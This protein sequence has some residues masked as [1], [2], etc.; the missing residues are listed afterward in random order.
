MDVDRDHI[1]HLVNGRLREGNPR[2]STRRADVERMVGAALAK[3][4]QPHLVV[5]FH[6]GLVNEK[7]GRG[8]AKKLAPSYVGANRYPLFFVWEAGLLEAIGNNLEDIR[9]DPI[10][11]Q[12]VKKVTRTVLT[13]LPAAAGFKGAGTKVDAESLEGEFDEWFAGKRSTLPEALGGKPSDAVLKGGAVAEPS[14]G[15]LQAR[16]QGELDV[17]VELQ[18]TLERV[19]A[20]ITPESLANPT[21]K[22]DAPGAVVSP[23]TEISPEQV[24]EVLDVKQGKGALS[25]AKVALLIARVAIRVIR[26]FIDGRAHGLYNTVVEEILAAAYIDKVGGLIWGQI[27]KDTEDAFADSATSGGAALLDIIAAQQKAAAKSFARITLIGHSTGAIYICNWLDHA[28]AALP[29]VK[30][31]VIFLAPAVTHAR[32]AKTLAGNAATIGKFRLF[33]MHDEV[34]SADRL[35]SI[36][37]TRSLLYFVSGVVEFDGGKRAVDE[38]LVGMERYLIDPTFTAQ[39]FPAVAAVKKFLG[40]AGFAIWSKTAAGAAAG[41]TTLSAKHGDFDDDPQTVA[42]LVHILGNGF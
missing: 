29:G 36:V 41:S 23:L 20:T 37:Y 33:G 3:G 22:I 30:F 27:K 42:S 11:R 2:S 34:E 15:D 14:E 28:A 25:L 6:G 10:F 13:Q 31:E 17:D 40:G 4:A 26:R 18:E 12:L 9:R 24:G 39:A 21:P 5:H 19:N 1:I 32:M 7:A 8:V 38:P 35:V 16:I